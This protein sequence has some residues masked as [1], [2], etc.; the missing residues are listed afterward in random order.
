MQG[1]Q[2]TSLRNKTIAK[3]QK[4]LIKLWVYS[5]Q[6]LNICL[7]CAVIG[8]KQNLPRLNILLHVVKH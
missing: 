5:Q 2:I 1:W 6:H 7:K 4:I 8:E 3:K